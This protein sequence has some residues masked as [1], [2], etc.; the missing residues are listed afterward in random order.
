M[1]TLLMIRCPDPACA[2]REPQSATVDEAWLKERLGAGDVPLFGA[3]CGHNW[4]MTK[5]E[6]D[7]TRKAMAEGLL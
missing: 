2:G 4:K 7:N 1:A 3:I 5:Q 6:M